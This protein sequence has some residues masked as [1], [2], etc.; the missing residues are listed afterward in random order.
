MLELVA[1]KMNPLR[2]MLYFIC[3]SFQ[4]KWNI[5][6]TIQI[7]LLLKIFETKLGQDLCTQKWLRLNGSLLT[8][9]K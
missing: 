1:Y 5:S 4:R 8:L 6:Q 7:F 3:V 9:D 2:N